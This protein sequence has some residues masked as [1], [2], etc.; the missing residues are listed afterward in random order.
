MAVYS[1]QDLLNLYALGRAMVW[2]YKMDRYTDAALETMLADLQAARREI[3]A[4]FAAQYSGMGDWTAD[5][6]EQ[7]LYAL[8][9]M[10]AGA[11]RALGQDILEA[12]A[13]AGASSS[14]WHMA[15]ITVEG[16][17]AATLFNTVS[18]PAEQL[19][20]LYAETPLG[21]EALAG[22]V[23]R[24]FDHAV[25]AKMR[26]ALNTGALL[27]EGYPGLV[28]RLEDGFD[29]LTRTEAITLARTYIQSAN[30]GAQRRVFEANAGVVQGLRWTTTLDT[31]TCPR[32]AALDGRIYKTG[33]DRPPMPLHPR[34]RCVMTPS[35]MSWR[36]MGIP[37]DELEEAARPF[38]IRGPGNVDEGGRRAIIEVGQHKGD[39]GAWWDKLP[40][41]QQARVIGPRRTELVRSGRVA[42]RDLVDGKTG[43]LRTLKELEER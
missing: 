21:G 13:Q 39:F 34:C 6:L 33:Q 4:K 40:E 24:T 27:G 10:T 25:Q 38:T 31:S 28:R 43:E 1:P 29:Q 18:L 30:V 16:A 14:A 22:W 32:C 11:R 35:L 17:A 26:S 8:D 41:E 36:D 5:R 9:D 7:V 2:R 37:L 19:R 42:F 15:T 3:M 20:S 23:N 12:S